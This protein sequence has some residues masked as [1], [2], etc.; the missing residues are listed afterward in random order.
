VANYY[1][2]SPQLH[3]DIAVFPGDQPF[4]RAIKMSFGSGDHL[5]LSS[6]QAS[7][8]VGAHADAPSH[9]GA[10]GQSIET[11]DLNLYI[12]PCSII[13][14]SAQPGERIGVKHLSGRARYQKRVLFATAS[15]PDPDVWRPNF[16]SL[17]SE[18]IHYLADQGVKLVGIDTPSVDP[19]DSKLLESHQALLKLDMAVLEGLVL[20]SVSEG[21]YFLVALPLSIRNADASPVRAV[22]WPLEHQWR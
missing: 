21:E 2:I 11:R 20:T 13:K 1:D 3:E 10:S 18:L 5:E 17:S 6:I 7:L 22:L 4:Q 14:I 12:G 15:F 9:Y 16:N 19:A 8:H